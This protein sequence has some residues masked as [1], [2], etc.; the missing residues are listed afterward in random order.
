M[1][2]LQPDDDWK[3]LIDFLSDWYWEQDKDLR[4]TMMTGKRMREKNIDASPIIGKLRWEQDRILDVNDPHWQAH[5]ALHYARQPFSNFTYRI[6]ARNNELRY[7]RISGAPF[8][9]ANGAF[10][11]YRGIGKDV[12]GEVRAELRRT[13]E[14][15]VTETLSTASSIAECVPHIIQ[16][17][18]ETQNW[19]C[20]IYWELDTKADVLKYKG[21]WC[22]DTDDAR[23]LLRARIKGE[24]VSR[25]VACI[26]S[27]VWQKG[28]PVW[29]AD[30]TADSDTSTSPTTGL[31]SAFAFPIKSGDEVIA[32]LEFYGTKIYQP[33]TE[34]LD[35]VAIVS[36][37]ISQFSSLMCARIELAHSEERF[38]S[39]IEL[40]SDWIWEQ[41]EDFCFTFFEGNHSMRKHA[42][43]DPRA[44]IGKYQW[45][46]ET[47]NLSPQDWVRHKE[48]LQRHETF[49]NFLIRRPDVNGSECWLSISGRPIFDTS[50]GFRGYRGIF[51]DISESKSSEERIQ[52]LATHDSLTRLPNRMMFSELLNHAILVGR[53]YERKFAVFFIDLDRFKVINDSLGH[54]AG[55]LLLKTT[56]Q[57]LQTCVRESDVVA[58]LGGD[59]FVVMVQVLSGIEGVE[60]VA[61]KI[62][63]TLF[64]P[65]VLMGQECRVTGSIGISL[66]PE[67]AQ[68]EQTLIKNADAAMYQAKESGKNRFAFYSETSK[69]QSLERMV[70]ETNLRHAIERKQLFLHYQA[71][72][73]LKSKRVTGVEALVRWEHPDLGTVSP[74]H[75]IPLA[76]ETGLIFP[77]GR[78]VLETACTQAMAWQKAGMAEMIM[79]VNVSPR[80]FS[81]HALIDDV[82]SI[83]AKTG[84]RGELLELELT[85]SMVVH[86]P[87][88]TVLILQALKKLGVRIAIDDF[89]T[90]YSSLAQLKNFPIDTLKVDRSFICDVSTNV[91]DQSMT[92]AIIAMGKSLGLTVVAEGVETVEQ[93]AFLAANACDETQGFYFSRPISA[94]AL[95]AMIAAHL[96]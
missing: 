51:K 81:D 36:T 79:A 53:R 61:K 22:A 55:D 26:A 41:D 73:D 10:A 63:T 38:R 90:G 89:G 37:H 4:F 57:R 69:L 40:S 65:V 85:E 20:G 67:H 13:I 7:I 11:G 47:L 23:T 42:G 91:D 48:T 21:N 45:D 82:R 12:T 9:D 76:E 14:H 15:A 5:K 58:R 34:L 8:F 25:D 87:D 88:R 56:A 60:T 19:A 49:E 93:Q 3:S 74:A 27:S 43:I 95:E 80:Q 17:L 18:C 35:C 62:L 92:K 6:T 77:I 33:D 68:D 86:D 16:T 78:W 1:N 32:V 83:L 59:E 54:E 2:A 96:G 31:R 30:I 70:L 66:Y 44:H 52:F 46:M 29:I 84:M 28:E 39:L 71:K 50:G 75:F 64:K 72:L 94:E 24:T